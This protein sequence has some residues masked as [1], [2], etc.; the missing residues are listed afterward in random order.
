MNK[1]HIE[2]LISKVPEIE[3]LLKSFFQKV[4]VKYS[5]SGGGGVALIGF[6]DYSWMEP[7]GEALKT[8]LELIDKYED[9]YS[10]TSQIINKITP[11]RKPDLVEL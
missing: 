11:G 5:P 1:E 3:G 8:Q 7:T 10:Q 6:S 4:Q 9:W 2:S